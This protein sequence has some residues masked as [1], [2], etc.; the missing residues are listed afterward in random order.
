[1]PESRNRK[2]VRR[3]QP[4]SAKVGVSPPWYAPVMVTLMV[5]G[6]LWIVVFYVTG[7]QFPVPALGNWNLGIGFGLIMAGFLMTT[8]WK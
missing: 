7:G 5:I 1:M 8:N 4:T 6:L 2:S 3:D